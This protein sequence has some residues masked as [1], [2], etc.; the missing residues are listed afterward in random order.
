MKGAFAINSLQKDEAEPLDWLYN[1][2][3][4]RWKIDGE[5]R[6]FDFVMDDYPTLL[7]GKIQNY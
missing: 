2:E 1:N 3:P 5:I 4:Q 7:A 6:E